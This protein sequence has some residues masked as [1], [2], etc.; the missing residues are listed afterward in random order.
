MFNPVTPAADHVRSEEFSSIDGV[1]DAALGHDILFGMLVGTPFT[2]LVVVAVCLAASIGVGNAFAVAAVP[3]VL[4]GIF[5]GGVF[6][7]TRQ[8]AHHEA[9]ER[10]ARQAVL[11][12]SALVT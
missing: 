10:V 2:Y 6:P 9:A 3:C 7:L 1:S 5:F 11:A 8:M 4:S 12:R